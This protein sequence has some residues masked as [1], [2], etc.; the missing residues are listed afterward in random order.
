MRLHAVRCR[1]PAFLSA[2]LLGTLGIVLVSTQAAWAQLGSGTN[3]GVVVNADG[4][5]QKQIVS[6]PGGRLMRERIA[7]AKSELNPDVTKY[8]K[9]RKISLNRLEAAIADGNGVLT[10]EMRKLAGLLRVKY[11]F[12][13]PETKDIVLAGPAEGWATNP[14]GRVVGMTSNRPTLLLE[15][16]V[17]ALRA[18]PPGADGGN[19]LIGCSIDPTREGLA[20]MQD[21][22]RQ[23]GTTFIGAPTPAVVERLAA[24]LQTSLGLQNVR[25]DGID[26]DTH[27]AQVM[28]EADY[29]MKLIGIGQERPPVKMVSFV[30]LADP[31]QVARNALQ[32]WYFVP[33]YQCVRVSDDGLAMQLVGDGVKLVG[34]DEAVTAAGSRRKASRGNRASQAFVTTFTKKYS[35]LAERSP[36]FAQLRN[37]IDLAVAAAFIQERDYYGK[38]DWNMPLFGDESKLAVRKYNAPAK[39]DSVVAARLKGN[40]LMTPIGGGVRIEAGIAL[41]QE[42]TLSDEKGEVGSLRQSLTPDLKKGQWWWD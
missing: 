13:Y 40:R 4:V 21:F 12:F 37:L 38:A 10:D 2:S 11:V 19:S 1:I 30:D 39:V 26:P 8:S 6:D 23:T 24:G 41:D 3:A 28:V 5:L 17:V 36:V 32:R 16:L 34:E 20:A 33:D 15:D 7:A 9:L 25:V 31:G 18:F 29:R 22:L 14:A 35:V 27:F 42:N